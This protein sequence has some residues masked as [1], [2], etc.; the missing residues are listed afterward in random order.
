VVV[1]GRILMR[2]RRVL[3]LNPAAVLA[4]ARQLAEKVRAAVEVAAPQSS[5]AR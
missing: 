5:V 1:N 2:D 3:T 4:D